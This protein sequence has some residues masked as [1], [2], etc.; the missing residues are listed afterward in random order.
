MSLAILVLVKSSFILM[1]LLH[2]HSNQYN[3]IL[4]ELWLYYMEAAM[5]VIVL[6]LY[7]PVVDIFV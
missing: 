3:I 2:H 5:F 7:N 4:I 1:R 6:K